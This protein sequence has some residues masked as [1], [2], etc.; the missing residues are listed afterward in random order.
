M[1][2]SWNEG[3]RGAQ[4]GFLPGGVERRDVRAQEV[5]QVVRNCFAR[6]DA[7]WRALDMKHREELFME[8]IDG[9][10]DVLSD[11]EEG[12]DAVV[13]RVL[14]EKMNSF[15]KEHPGV[16]ERA[17]FIRFL[18]ESALAMNG[19]E[20]HELK[21]FLHDFYFADE[22]EEPFFISRKERE[23]LSR[24]LRDGIVLADE[25]HADD[26]DYKE[27]S[28]FLESFRNT[29]EAIRFTE[30]ADRISDM[31][32]QSPSAVSDAYHAR[33]RDIVMD[34]QSEL[35]RGILLARGFTFYKP[36]HGNL[37]V[38]RQEV[39]RLANEG[40]TFSRATLLEENIIVAVSG[41]L[42]QGEVRPW[43]RFSFQNFFPCEERVSPET[44]VKAF[45]QAV[46]LIDMDLEGAL[47]RLEK[48]C[49]GMSSY[50]ETCVRSMFG[51]LHT[52]MRDFLQYVPEAE[53]D[54]LWAS[55]ERVLCDRG[56]VF[57]ARWQREQESKGVKASPVVSSQPSWSVVSVAPERATHS[58]AHAEPLV[59]KPALR[60]SVEGESSQKKKE[61]FSSEE[62]L[63]RIQEGALVHLAEEMRSHPKRFAE[64]LK[65]SAVQTAA[66]RALE[67]HMR[68]GS[69]GV[70][71]RAAPLF[72]GEDWREEDPSLRALARGYFVNTIV[73]EKRGDAGHRLPEAVLRKKVAEFGFD[74]DAL[75]QEAKAQLPK[76]MKKALS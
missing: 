2:Q 1:T 12:D 42:T 26:A 50:T 64:A 36:G 54:R 6:F 47:L 53:S 63:A 18:K 19:V 61:A 49:G 24:T 34:E 37:L 66:W 9:F 4:G 23:E 74:W 10:R 31:I 62:V 67:K 20:R 7:H 25:L 65:D 30:D 69:F 52:F 41:L 43:D 45:S 72:L 35:W 27:D 8:A 68:Q 28:R 55:F 59:I 21:R 76:K 11:E 40:L 46:E 60:T 3:L 16:R 44:S 13:A 39:A 56:G 15:V 5:E 33:I 58:G 71:E 22:R 29:L 51:C 17:S 73:A 38:K 48:A 57:Y 70:V 32:Q 14:H 75:V